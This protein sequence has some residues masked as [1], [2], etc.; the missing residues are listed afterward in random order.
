MNAFAFILFSILF[1]A[2]VMAHFLLAFRS[3]KISRR[4]QDAEIDLNYVRLEDYFARS[5]RLKLSEWIRLPVQA[6]K[7]DGTR[8][9][10]K[11][12][13][14]VR[15]VN[16]TS[17]PEGSASDDILAVQGDFNCSASC[18]FHREIYVQGNA[19]IGDGAQLQAIAS[20]GNLALG[21]KVRIARWADCQGDM[22]IGERSVIH[23][24]A[25]A[26]KSLLLQK[27]AQVKSAFAPSVRTLGNCTIRSAESDPAAPPEISFPSCMTDLE[28]GSHSETGLDPKQLRMLSPDC[29]MYNGDFKPSRPVHVEAKLIVRGDCT[30]PSGSVLDQ[31][32]KGKKSISIGAGCI[33]R[34][35]VISDKSIR[36][37]PFS[38]FYGVVHAGQTLRICS[39]VRGG[40]ENAHVA[41]FAEEVLTVEENVI[42][43][44]K[45]A[46][47]NCVVAAP[48]F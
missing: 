23:S 28:N 17:C 33:C 44:G 45:L 41:A 40:A 30:V 21:A 29:W 13:E 11:G 43:H 25:T 5:F 48:A 38:Q 3:W 9:I 6:C 36:L 37:G 1:A 7:P 34:G 27:R 35:S 2:L 16:S 19:R 46:S 32:I 14:T 22:E 15:V 26:G 12:K 8:L 24:R 4:D 39:G 47:G 31:D 10:R 20:D 42:V 18:T